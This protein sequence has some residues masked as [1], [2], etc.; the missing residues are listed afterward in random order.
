MSSFWILPVSP[1]HVSSM[2]LM[3]T[4]SPSQSAP[5]GM[6]YHMKSLKWP[7]GGSINSKMDRDTAVWA[8]TSPQ[9]RIGPCL[10]P[11]FSE[12]PR[13]NYLNGKPLFNLMGRPTVEGAREV[14]AEVFPGELRAFLREKEEDTFSAVR[15]WWDSEIHNLSELFIQ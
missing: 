3:K 14:K 13:D 2:N 6:A 10:A 1:K 5:L 12:T 4:G 8:W 7:Q 15:N 11:H 9:V